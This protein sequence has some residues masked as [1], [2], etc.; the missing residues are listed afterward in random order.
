MIIYIGDMIKKIEINY[1]KINL[2]YIVFD[3]IGSFHL[4]FDWLIIFKY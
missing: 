3:D 4:Y 2:N 1:F